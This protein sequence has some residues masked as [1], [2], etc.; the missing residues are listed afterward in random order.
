M[1]AAHGKG[2]YVMVDVVA[3]H[4]APIPNDD[5]SQIHPFNSAD[6]Y[7][8]NCAINDFG[9]QWQ[10]ENCRLAGLPDLKQENNWVR[11]QLKSW[12][13]KLV[14]DF[15]FDG[16]R[17]DTIPEVPKDFWSEYGQA[18]GVFQMGECFN[19]DPAYVGPYQEHVT[20]LFNYPMYYTIKDVFG[21]RKS[22]YNIKTRFSQE[23]GHFN[24]IDALGIFVD[25]HDNPRFLNQYSDQRMFKNALVFALT[26]RGIPF[27]YYGSEQAYAGGADPHNR[28][29][30]WQ[31]MNTDSDIYK[32]T[33]TVN[34][35]RKAHNIGHQQQMERYVTD[36]FYAYARGDVLVALTN[37]H[38]KQHESIPNAPWSDGTEVCNA[39]YPTTDCQTIQNKTIDVWLADGESKIYLPKSSEVIQQAWAEKERL[40][41]VERAKLGEEEIE[42]E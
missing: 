38:D 7:H 5:W 17:I 37:T 33:A 3:N 9:N 34:R 36:N 21:S 35:V 25:N 40:E 12:I 24:D 4:V 39:F 2:M 13:S 18:A 16:I 15:G 26:A 22:M 6:H 30:L 23:E 20:G 27:Y 31:A 41:M 1:N 19:G 29:S 42:K 28:E 10:V 14:K 8:P 11:D 32:M